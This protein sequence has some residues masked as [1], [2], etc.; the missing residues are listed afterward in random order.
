MNTRAVK[1]KKMFRYICE[2]LD[3]NLN[4]PQCREIKKCLDSCP[5]CD[6]YLKSLKETI[7]LYRQYPT[8][9]ISIKTLKKLRSM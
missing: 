1:Y 2:N 9:G 8:P 7:L 6:A 4:S 3:K 5:D